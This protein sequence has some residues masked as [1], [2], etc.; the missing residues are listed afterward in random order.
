[1]RQI[2][3]Y[4]SRKE[5]SAV[6]GGPLQWYLPTVNRKIVAV[7]LRKNHNPKAPNVVFC[8]FGTRIELIGEWLSQETRALPVFVKED[9]NR[10]EYHGR[11]KVTSSCT[12][13]PEFKSEVAGAEDAASISRVV[14]MERAYK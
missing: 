1:M 10:W 9:M 5:I 2:G 8:G 14:F 3:S 13:G 4:Y 6:L 12:S 7:C 11:F